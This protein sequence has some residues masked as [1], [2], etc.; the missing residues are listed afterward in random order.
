MELT[1]EGSITNAK[2]IPSS[3]FNVTAI[4]SISSKYKK[5]RN[6]S[7]APTFA[8]TY[9]GSYKTLMN[10]CGFSE[11]MAKKVEHN[12]HQ[13]YTVSD[14]WVKS[15]LNQAKQDGYVTVAFG[16]KLRTP[17]LVQ[18]QAAP[19]S[20]YEAE[21]RTAGNALGQSWGLLNSRAMNVV[22]Q[23]VR[24]NGYELD[25]LPVAA[26]HDCNYYLIRNN[27]SLIS[28]FNSVVREE[29]EWNDHPDIYHDEV[30]L[31]GDLDIFYP[32]WATPL[33]LPADVTQE[34]LVQL[35]QR[36]LESLDAT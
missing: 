14:Q 21:G 28:W 24:A 19:R 31:G 8:L 7:K 1:F 25:I 16:L 4:N 18:G 11:G 35:V 6:E 17:L 30:G 20:L 2:K 26:I 5:W 10:N 36:H 13:L 29:A 3:S 34:S 12:Y 27:A 15:K 32:S 9:G 33:T 22:M 23:R